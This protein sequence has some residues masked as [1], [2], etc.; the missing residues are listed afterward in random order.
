MKPLDRISLRRK[1][2]SLR[3]RPRWKM[4]GISIFLEEGLPQ[5]DNNLPRRKPRLSQKV[6]YSIWIS[7][8]V[9]RPKLLRQHRYKTFR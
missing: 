1:R 9:E 5:L 8:E 2:R 7:S 3:K 4:K 6:T